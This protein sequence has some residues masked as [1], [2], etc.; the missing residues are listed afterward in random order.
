MARVPQQMPANA[1]QPIQA[2]RVLVVDD[3]EIVRVMLD[4]ILTAAAFRVTA[5]ATPR[6]AVELLHQGHGF[7]AVV[8]DLVM[9]EKTGID[10]LREIRAFGHRELPLIILTGSPTLESAMAAVGDAHVR[11]LAK[12]DAGRSLLPALHELVDAP[13]A[14]DPLS[15][16]GSETR[17]R[18]SE[19]LLEEKNE[20]F[21]AALEL[22]WV[23]FQPIISWKAKKVFG[24]EALVRSSHTV[25]SHPGRLF[26]AA[27]Q[28][29]RLSDISR[30][31]RGLVAASMGGAPEDARVFVNLH[32]SDLND[33]ELYTTDAPLSRYADRIVLE[34][35]ER[36]SL[37]CVQN[38]KERL[39]RLREAGFVIAVDD[40]G[41]GYAGLA[42]F[43]QLEPEVVKLD[44]SLVRNID[45]QPRI[46][47]VV[48]SMLSACGGDLEILVV[49]EGV[50][51]PAERDVLV[52]LGAD[53]L[54]GYLFGR[55]LPGF[56]QATF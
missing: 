3:D 26:E 20:E 9:P 29:N 16:R 6:E 21:D 24:Y 39:R 13:A 52:A 46:Q 49:C 32:S 15:A 2:K 34:V 36:A 23:A 33:D 42:S 50:E 41:A 18:N 4:E 28:L 35:T 10:L 14:G 31:I 22:L 54:Q 12:A 55:P 11:Y 8:T 43:G 5:V 7:A 56:T 38:L 19:A 30:R 40:L 27:E 47:R 37:D 51:T 1:P 53:L 25:L 17:L 45:S 44:M 48:Q